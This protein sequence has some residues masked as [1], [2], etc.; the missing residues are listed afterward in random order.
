MITGLLRGA[1]LCVSLVLAVSLPDTQK[2]SE[3]VSVT[4]MAAEIVGD[5]EVI[6]R[7]TVANRST[8]RLIVPFQGFPWQMSTPDHFV[9]VKNS[10]VLPLPIS[11]L[12]LL[13]EEYPR[14]ISPGEKVEGSIRL[15]RLGPGDYS[16]TGIVPCDVQQEG[17]NITR[18]PLFVPGLRFT[19]PAIGDSSK[20]P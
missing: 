6:L 5:N 2:D 3:L 19:I 9:F 13:C 10:A 8:T 14:S 17:K 4:S 7:M 1:A 16:L 20:A 11:R 15:N 12:V 18:L